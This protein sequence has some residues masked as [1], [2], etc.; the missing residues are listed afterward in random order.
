VEPDAAATYGFIK[1]FGEPM[2]DP[3][4]PRAAESLFGDVSFFAMPA[5][6]GPA[7]ETE[8]AADR[9]GRLEDLEWTSAVKEGQTRKARV[10]LPAGYDPARRY[11]VLYVHEGQDA[12]EQGRMQTALDHM[13]GATIEPLIAV[14]IL[15]DDENPRR[16]MQPMETYVKMVVTELVPLVDGKYSTI[17]SPAGR[18]V[19]GAGSG[20]DA[21]MK[22]A[23]EESNLFGRVGSQSGFLGRA[24]LEPVIPSADERPLTMYFDWGTYHM[25]SPHEAWDIAEENLG[26]W[27]LLRER[28]Y[29]PAGGEIPEGFGWACFRAHVDD[30]LNALF[31]LPD[32]APAGTAAVERTAM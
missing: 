30:M 27:A 31:P 16:D 12:L 29:R 3:R 26:T 22:C 4:N 7:Y 32:T 2:A 6:P 1:D 18:G 5:W 21:A 23:F 19:V 11:P 13:I 17:A 15:L 8:A 9:R 28:G 20:A 10:Y 25:R 24:E 14:F